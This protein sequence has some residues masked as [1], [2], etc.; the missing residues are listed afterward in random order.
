MFLY[1]FIDNSTDYGIC[2]TAD[3]MLGGEFSYFGSTTAG[4]YC[5]AVF[6]LIFMFVCMLSGD[7][8]S[9]GCTTAGNYCSDG[10]VLTL[11]FIFTTCLSFATFFALT[12]K[13]WHL[14]FA[15]TLINIHIFSNTL[16]INAGDLIYSLFKRSFSFSH[17]SR[18]STLYKHTTSTQ[19]SFLHASTAAYPAPAVEAYGLKCRVYRLK[20]FIYR[21]GTCRSSSSCVYL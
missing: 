18:L 7:F 2:D 3:G 19:D 16:L 8:I 17:L 10:F 9:F 20:I 6:L 12:K 14:V 15:L 13:K 1:F 11:V 4:N 5:S 21:I